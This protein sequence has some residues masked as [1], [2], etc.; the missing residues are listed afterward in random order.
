MPP[1]SV[2]ACLHVQSS[3]HVYENKLMVHTLGVF[4][5]TV[6]SDE[7][8]KRAK[9]KPTKNPKRLSPTDLLPKK[10]F[11]SRRSDESNANMFVFFRLNVTRD[12]S[13][14]F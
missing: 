6:L 4:T 3:E 14:L 1:P 10:Q 5:P 7:L 9:K 2:S 12:V 8:I 11:L 13:G